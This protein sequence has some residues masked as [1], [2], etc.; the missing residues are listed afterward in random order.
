[1]QKN[2]S[3]FAPRAVG[4]ESFSGQATVA[5]PVESVSWTMATEFCRRLSNFGAEK[6]AGRAYRL[7]TEAEWEYACRAGSATRWYFG[8]DES[9]L[10]S[11]AWFSEKKP[12]AIGQKKPNAWGLYDMLGNVS[13]WCADRFAQDYY[14]DSPSIDPAGPSS[15]VERVIRGGSWWNS[16]CCRSAARVGAEAE[17]DET[18]GLRVVCEIGAHSASAHPPVLP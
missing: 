17:G 7:P 16:A 5:L 1:M 18:I 13:E 14:K 6:S 12:Q 4:R 15:G 10:A 3:H 11:Y 8:D 2:P 9:A